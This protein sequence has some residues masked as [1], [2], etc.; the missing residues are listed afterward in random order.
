MFYSD[1]K[2]LEEKYKCII[3][4]KNLSYFIGCADIFIATSST[5]LNWSILCDIP[6]IA[7]YGKSYY[8]AHLK[9]INSEFDPNKLPDLIKKILKSNKSCDKEDFLKLSRDEVFFGKS[10]DLHYKIFKNQIKK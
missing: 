9:S 2:F 10:L 4:K 7:I 8:Y 3:I 5:T 1:Y 6:T